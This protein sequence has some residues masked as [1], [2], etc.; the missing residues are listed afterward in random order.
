MAVTLEQKKLILGNLYPYAPRAIKDGVLVVGTIDGEV[1]SAEVDLL[2]I[3]WDFE[4]GEVAYKTAVA[5]K[6]E[7]ISYERDIRV[8][9]GMDW[10]FGGTTP[11]IIQ[12][13]DKDKILLLGLNAKSQK[14]KGQGVVD[15]VIPIRGK[16]NIDH[17][18][19]PDE[20]IN[21][22]FAA[23]SYVSD[24][25]QQSWD[26]KKAIADLP[27]DANVFANIKAIDWPV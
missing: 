25:Y 26:M 8:N 7:E 12:T 21:L 16:S 23:G 27:R 10:V 20:A 14:L 24:V 22:T 2:A 15:P 6:F 5:E 1:G 4:L 13:R 18:V 19:T 3:D 11:D 17:L 9:A